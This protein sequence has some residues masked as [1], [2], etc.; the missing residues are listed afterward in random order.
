[1]ADST[2]RPSLLLC[3]ADLLLALFAHASGSTRSS[4]R[5]LRRA[6][7]AGWGRVVDAGLPKNA[8]FGDGTDYDWYTEPLGIQTI[9]SEWVVRITI[10]RNY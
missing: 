9:T 6:G 1:M 4:G 10:S 2:L 5:G 8:G 7:A 3:A